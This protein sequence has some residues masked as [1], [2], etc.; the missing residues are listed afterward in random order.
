M[1]DST[2]SNLESAG[3]GTRRRSLPQPGHHCLQVRLTCLSGETVFDDIP[4]TANVADIRHRLAESVGASPQTI[5]IAFA[6]KSVVWPLLDDD[7][8][9]VIQQDG[10]VCLCWRRRPPREVYD[11]YHAR[12]G[13]LS[14]LGKMVE[15]D[16]VPLELFLLGLRRNPKAFKAVVPVEA[17]D[18]LQEY[19]S[20]EFIN[21]RMVSKE[22]FDFVQSWWLRRLAAMQGSPAVAP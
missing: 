3:Q 21:R 7:F 15:T 20:V 12:T 4:V 8:L 9:Q 18:F 11:V 13:D 10:V 6:S 16:N 5:G 14:S 19:E 17:N 1:E 2:H 22:L